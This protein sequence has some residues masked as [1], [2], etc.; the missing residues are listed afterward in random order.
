MEPS[1]LAAQMPSTQ[2]DRYL[3]STCHIPDAVDALMIP[4][5]VQVHPA[6]P[7]PPRTHLFL[8][9]HTLLFALEALHLA[10]WPMSF[11]GRACVSS[12]CRTWRGLP[13]L[14]KILI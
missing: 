3:L 9:S 7:S 8:P 11:P 5:G 12:E 4:V 10:C 1:S 2:L 14:S 13:T 6:F